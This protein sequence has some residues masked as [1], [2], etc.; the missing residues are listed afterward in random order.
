MLDW[1]CQA[2]LADKGAWRR[3][4]EELTEKC[5]PGKGASPL[6]EQRKEEEERMVLKSQSHTKICREISATQ[7]VISFE[8]QVDAIQ[9]RARA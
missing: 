3:I 5:K 9:Y 6:K 2:M 8:G 1:C 7:P 4:F